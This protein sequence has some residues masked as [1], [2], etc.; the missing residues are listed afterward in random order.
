MSKL[1]VRIMMRWVSIDS[2]KN[3]FTAFMDYEKVRIGIWES[4]DFLNGGSVFDVYIS[5]VIVG[6]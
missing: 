2:T 5:I 3:T 1:E 4:E 6:L